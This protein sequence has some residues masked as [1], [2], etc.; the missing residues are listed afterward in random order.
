MRALVIDDDP[1]VVEAI[2]VCFAIRWPDVEVLAA[3]N[4]REGIELVAE[5]RPQVVILD[6]SLPDIDGYAVCRQIRSVSEVPVIMLTARSS[7][8]EKVKGLELGA[9]DYITKPFSHIELLARVR[10]VL[11]R[12]SAPNLW[13]G[14]PSYVSPGLTVDF[15]AREVCCRGAHI[16]LTPIEYEILCQLVR[17]PGQVLPHR[18]L[19]S[20]VWGP[21]YVNE[22]G[23]LK[24]HIHN[25]RLKLEDDPDKPVMILTER[26]AGY[27]F[28]PP[29][30]A[31]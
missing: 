24:V 23:Y 27:R 2:Q 26:G 8:L 25:L 6:I 15:G 28:V 13:S 7:E 4:G 3:G 30:Q 9:D 31:S 18:T 19:L 29:G 12:A 20:R 5:E 21:E 14:L 10:A 1:E 11:R 17:N 16:K 22:V